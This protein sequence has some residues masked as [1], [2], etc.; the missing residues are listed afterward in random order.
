MR[1]RPEAG[2]HVSHLMARRSECVENTPLMQ[3]G[4]G[5]CCLWFSIWAC[6]ALHHFICPC[7]VELEAR[8]MCTLV[9]II[10]IPLVY[11]FSV[12]VM[13]SSELCG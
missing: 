12:V 6:Y 9:P 13:L 2:D 7:S 3:E 10:T 1:R 8:G 11:L 4:A 5:S